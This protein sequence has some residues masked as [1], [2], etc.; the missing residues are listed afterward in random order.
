MGKV[1]PNLNKTERSVADLSKKEKRK[2]RSRKL[3][4][5]GVRFGL[6]AF[7]GRLLAGPAFSLLSASPR[8][9]AAAV[10]VSASSTA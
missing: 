7:S 5:R 4:L 2:D 1:W 10:V 9:A 3:L 8:V 6:R